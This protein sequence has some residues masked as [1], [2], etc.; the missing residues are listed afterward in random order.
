MGGPNGV[1]LLAWLLLA[2]IS[3]LFTSSVLPEGELPGANPWLGLAVGTIG[4]LVTGLV[5]WIGKIS[6][7]RNTDVKPKPT[8]TL[9]VFAIAGLIRGFAVAYLLEAFAITARADYGQRMASG[10]ALILVWF[11]VSAV[12]VDG[13]KGYRAA[14]FRLSEELAT[15]SQSMSSNALALQKTQRELMSQIRKTLSDALRAGSSSEDIHR[16]VDELIRPLSH[17]LAET[18]SFASE[19]VTGV[20]RRIAF[21]PVLRTA[22]T[23]TPFNPGW[24]FLMAVVGTIYSKF[25]QF[26]PVALIDSL[27]TGI[28]IW[29]VF[30]GAKRLRLRGVLAPVVWFVTGALAS[31]ATA[32]L[33]GGFRVEGFPTVM[34]L[35]VNIFVP[36]A[37]VAAIGAFD[38]EVVKNLDR[39]RGA[40]DQ[41]RFQRAALDQR[42]WVEQQRLARFVHS[43]LQARLRAFALRLDLQGRMP[44]DQEIQELRLQCERSLATEGEQQDLEDFLKATAQL[45]QG[46]LSVSITISEDAV[47]ALRTDPY[48]SAAAIEVCREGLNNITKHGDANSAQVS[49]SMVTKGGQGVLRLEIKDNGSNPPGKKTGLGSKTLSELSLEWSRE[50]HDGG[51]LLVADLPIQGKSI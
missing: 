17:R 2:P 44:S 9:I 6:V 14:Y 10:A 47:S 8:L 48:A 51:V 11:S 41:V 26:G 42:Q 12:M 30:S 31:M 36:A 4:H 22:L 45:W 20:K 39:L 27:L 34:F 7:L 43:D 37:I 50:A 46:V 32:L 15:Q 19:P 35:S 25:W 28:I 29:A 23:D 13:I 3:I 16:A 1:T 24:T 49:I 38:R 21:G 18:S 40:V 33:I 5:L